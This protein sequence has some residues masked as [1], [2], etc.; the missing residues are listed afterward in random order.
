MVVC[1]WRVWTGG[2]LS[3]VWWFTCLG[4]F[5]WFGFAFRVEFAL[6]GFLVWLW[7]FASW[8]F[9]GATFGSVCVT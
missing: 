5:D 6:D 7:W 8:W 1:L 3:V 2:L 4:G 9:G